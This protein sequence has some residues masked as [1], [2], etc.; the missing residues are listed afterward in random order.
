VRLLL[1]ESLSAR[2]VAR[3]TEAG[4]DV[5]HVGDLD[6]LGA[7][8]DVVLA[9]AV[10]HRRI[11]MTADTDF[12]ALLAVSDASLPRV[13]LLRRGG[14]TKTQRAEQ[15]V[16]V[17]SGM[18]QRSVASDH[19]QPRSARSVGLGPVPSPPQGALWRL[20]SIE[21]SDRSSPMMRS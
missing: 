17:L 5:V 21:T 9:A 15:M 3:L 4:H 20:P 19:F 16:G 10:E 1:D 14:R 11:L 6:L 8:D 12:G 2:L 13:V 7:S 18:P